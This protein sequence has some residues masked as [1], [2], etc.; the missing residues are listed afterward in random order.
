MKQVAVENIRNNFPTEYFEIQDIVISN[1]DFS[2]GFKE[3][4]DQ[5]KI[6][7]QNALKE[8]NQV[9]VVKFQQQQEIERYKAEAEKL[10]L[11][12]SQITTLLIQ[13]QWINKWDGHLPAYMMTTPENANTLLQIPIAQPPAQSVATTSNV[14]ESG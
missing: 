11:Q 9:D 1:I 4:I 10:R 3:A 7:E 13:Q 5:K 2:V 12:K 8:K 14:T 6:A